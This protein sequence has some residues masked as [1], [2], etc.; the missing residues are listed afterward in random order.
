MCE[1]MAWNITYRVLPCTQIYKEKKIVNKNCSNS[2]IYLLRI[3]IRHPKS[4]TIS[5]LFFV[6]I[7]KLKRSKHVRTVHFEH[8]CCASF[9]PIQNFE[10]RCS[11]FSFLFVLFLLF[12]VSA[13]YC[14][15]WNM[16]LP[17][18]YTHTHRTQ[19][20]RTKKLHANSHFQ[21][22]ENTHRLNVHLRFN[23]CVR[24]A[25]KIAYSITCCSSISRF[26]CVIPLF[27]LVHLFGY[28]RRSNNIF[29][30]ISKE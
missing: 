4:I 11:A 30:C 21:T 22:K 3:G 28:D 27:H 1:W 5:S 14:F 24:K 29:D 7:F 12:C 16:C 15:N 8:C 26:V 25:N 20:F 13:F 10:Y 18:I 19:I 9:N 6:F 2:N 23:L 17:N